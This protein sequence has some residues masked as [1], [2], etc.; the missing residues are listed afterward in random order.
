MSL[1]NDDCRLVPLRGPVRLRLVRRDRAGRDVESVDGHL[2]AGCDGH[3]RPGRNSRIFCLKDSVMTP[4]ASG[5]PLRSAFISDLS[6]A[7]VMCGGSGGTSGS[8]TASM[9]NGRSA[10]NAAA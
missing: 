9:T 10:E 8:T 7:T 1:D 3:Y 5:S 6:A 4:R 2:D